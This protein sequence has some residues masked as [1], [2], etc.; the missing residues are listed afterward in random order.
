MIF[1]LYFIFQIKQYFHHC[2]VTVFSFN[3]V[4]LGSDLVQDFMN[5]FHLLR[6][7]KADLIVIEHTF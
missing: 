1:S 3:L 6:N 2:S 4:Q 5:E 7:L